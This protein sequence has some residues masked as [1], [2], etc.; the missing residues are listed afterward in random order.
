MSMLKGMHLLPTAALI[1]TLTLF[2][3]SHLH[4]EEI[5]ISIRRHQSL[6]ENLMPL[7]I[8]QNCRIV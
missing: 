1:D 8:S 6:Q 7:V 3:N 2:Q 4:F 5:L